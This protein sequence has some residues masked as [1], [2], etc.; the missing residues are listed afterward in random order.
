MDSND[1]NKRWS[2]SQLL[3]TPKA[4]LETLK[5]LS[6]PNT[7]PIIKGEDTVHKTLEERLAGFQGEYV[8]E[9]WDTDPPVRGEVL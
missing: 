5:A 7:V 9:E 2:S 6:E 8:F 4:M 3:T 1:K